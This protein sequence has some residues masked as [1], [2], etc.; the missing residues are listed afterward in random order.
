MGALAQGMPLATIIKQAQDLANQAKQHLGAKATTPSKLAR[1]QSCNRNAHPERS[2]RSVGNRYNAP[3][4]G[5]DLRPK[6]DVNRRGRDARATLDANR[7]QHYGT[8]PRVS[9][10]DYCAFAPNLWRVIWPRKF[11]PGPIEKYDGTTN[12]KEWIIIYSMVIEAAYGAN[13]VKAN[14]L[15]SVL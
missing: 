4:G 8:N 2:N 10:T 1:S 3:P 7:A 6:L 9:V 13:Y 11:K 12:P 5:R 14:H 15:P